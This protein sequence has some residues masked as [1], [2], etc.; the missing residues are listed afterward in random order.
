MVHDTDV[1]GPSIIM[2][3]TSAALARA[4]ASIR[5]QAILE[6]PASEFFFDKIC[7]CTKKEKA[8]NPKVYQAAI[9]LISD[10]T[11]L[12]PETAEGFAINAQSQLMRLEET[13]LPDKAAESEGYSD[14]GEDE[15]DL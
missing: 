4:S 7:S 12:D 13:P 6:D 11:D 8:E 2:P 3:K 9:D 14:E 5:A 15:I 1:G 10:P